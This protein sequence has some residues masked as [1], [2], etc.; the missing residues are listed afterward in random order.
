MRRILL[1][2][3]NG[4]VGQEFQQRASSDCA[5][6]ACGRADLDITNPEQ[7]LQ[8]VEE[9]SPDWIVNAAAY[10]AVDEAETHESAAIAVNVTG[11]ENLARAA[12]ESGAGFLHISTDFIF[13]GEKSSPYKPE[14]KARPISKYGQSKLEGERRVLETL[15]N[16]L[17]IRTG[18]VYSIHGKNFVKSMIRVMNE[19]SEI[20]VVEDQVGTPTWAADLV[21]VMCRS[22][23]ENIT[24]IHHWSDAGVASW[25][26]FAVAIYELGLAE[27]LV[28]P[29]VQIKPIPT[30]SY[31]TPA[32]RPTYSVLDKESL[33]KAASFQ[34]QHWRLSLQKMIKELNH[35]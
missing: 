22:M 28:R 23:D 3:A 9:T 5:V 29:G 33:R 25:Y 15:A 14:D 13:D 26:D 18:W 34:G 12:R 30:S 35:G 32:A 20:S 2:G 24:G 19:L 4:Q 1:A 10:T 11:A 8:V 16:A 21:T 6:I 27:G 7:V 31:P 17:I